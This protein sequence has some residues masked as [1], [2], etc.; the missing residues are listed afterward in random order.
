M[1]ERLHLLSTRETICE[2]GW[3]SLLC[4]NVKGDVGEAGTVGSLDGRAVEAKH[5]ELWR[6]SFSCVLSNTYNP[7]LSWPCMRTVRVERSLTKQE[8][9][10]NSKNTWLSAANLETLRRFF[11]ISGT[12]RS[13]FKASVLEGM[14]DDENEVWPMWWIG[15]PLPFPTNTSSD[16]GNCDLVRRLLRFGVRWWVAPESGY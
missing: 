4:H 8:V 7:P 13:C 10:W 14:N 12:W 5:E 3:P 15:R 2:E 6:G 16:E 11:V 9:G 1:W